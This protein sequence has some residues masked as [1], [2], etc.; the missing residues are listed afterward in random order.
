MNSNCTPVYHTSVNGTLHS[1]Y[2][3]SQPNLQAPITI[4]VSIYGGSQ[5]NLGHQHGYGQTYQPQMMQECFKTS[6]LPL[7]GQGNHYN[8]L[9]SNV[10]QNQPVYGPTTITTTTSE[11]EVLT[12][13][14]CLAFC[15]FIDVNLETPTKNPQWWCLFGAIHIR[16]LAMMLGCLAAI[17]SA[18]LG[19]LVT[20]LMATK[21]FSAQ[22]LSN[23]VCTYGP[24]HL[25]FDFA[26]DFRKFQEV[27]LRDRFLRD[28]GGYDAQPKEFEWSKTWQDFKDAEKSCS[29]VTRV[30]HTYFHYFCP[31][32]IVYLLMWF[33]GSVSMV[34]G[35][36]LH[37]L[38]L[39][40]PY[41]VL[42]ILDVIMSLAHFC[43]FI[44]LPVKY[45]IIPI[46]AVP[47]VFPL[48]FH[49]LFQIWALYM[50][51][52]CRL[53]VIAVNPKASNNLP[54]RKNGFHSGPMPITNV[55]VTNC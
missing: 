25:K 9:S 13:V 23:A 18:I 33:F 46:S 45:S 31:F 27:H 48:F 41:L 51:H 24:T 8:Q 1:A 42:R 52:I 38:P 35:G 49:V 11:P 19:V 50:A 37:R 10:S 5:P 44:V 14:N 2:Y 6:N 16:H 15:S 12:C 17:S 40:Y 47:L 3:Q 32:L 55:I 22:I 21:L 28:R 34:F 4:P 30:F 53:Y 43:F 36:Y 39:V 26:N 29:Q 7:P 20:Y 54:P